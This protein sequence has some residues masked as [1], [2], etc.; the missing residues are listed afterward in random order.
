MLGGLKNSMEK[1][2]KINKKGGAFAYFFWVMVGFVIGIIVSKA[3][4][5]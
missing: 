4:L 1:I 2:N 5:C 3:L